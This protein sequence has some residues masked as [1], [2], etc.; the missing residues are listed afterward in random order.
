MQLSI[1]MPFVLIDKSAP[2]RLRRQKVT[3]TQARITD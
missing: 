1:F 2:R 3:A